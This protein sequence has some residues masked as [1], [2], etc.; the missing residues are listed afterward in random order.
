MAAPAG[1][2]EA[3]LRRTGCR[4]AFDPADVRVTQLVAGAPAAP[5]RHVAPERTK[6]ESMAAPSL[7]GATRSI[8]PVRWLAVSRARKHGIRTAQTDPI[9]A[10]D[11]G[12]VAIGVQNH[13]R[14]RGTD[15]RRADERLKLTVSRCAPAH[16]RRR[17]SFQAPDLT[18]PLLLPEL[19]CHLQCTTRRG[20]CSRSS[21][22][23][24]STTSC[25]RSEG[26][27]STPDAMAWAVR[28]T[29]QRSG[30][31]SRMASR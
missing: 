23:L 2:R 21:C 20:A 16:R 19:S 24:H 18:V 31:W 17:D 5:A 9:E 7:A 27:G 22:S 10:N 29:D 30:S 25:P 28:S 12:V 13:E 1:T 11:H 15:D 8:D 6:N 3:T 14:C 26:T 4:C